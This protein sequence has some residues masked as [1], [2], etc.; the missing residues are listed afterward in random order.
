MSRFACLSAL[1]ALVAAINSALGQAVS[2]AG[3]Q[4]A[5]PSAS[6]DSSKKKTAAKDISGLE[7][8]VVTAERRESTVQKTPIS[9]TAVS[10]ADIL[11]RGL[12]DM[13]SIAQQTPGISFRTAGPGQTE[14]EMRGL[15]STGGFSPTVGFYVDD[16]PLTAPAE[17][18]QGKIVIDPDLYDLNR[19]EVLRGPQGTLYGS[20]SMGG[21]IKLVTNPP[22]LNKF[23]VSAQTKDSDTDGGGFNYGVSAMLNIPLVQD[24]VAL[25]L[26]G[27]D[28]YVAGWID[29]VVLNPF[30]LETNGG[31]SRGNILAAPVQERFSDVNWE[32][33]GGGRISLLIQIG[34]R[35]TITPGAMYQR[36]TQGG[37][38]T[39]D[40]PPGTQYAHFEP[41]DVDEP[42]EDDF[43]IYT[44][45][46]KYHFDAFDLSS[47]S[48]SWN[49]HDQQQTDISETM[50][51][52]FGFPSYDTVGA[53]AQHVVD[54]SSQFSQEIRLASNTDG[55]FQWLGGVF[56]SDFHSNTTSFIIYPGFG[57]L[58]GTT[59]L[60]NNTTPLTITQRALFGEASYKIT[61]QLKG[62]LG[63]RYYRY[64]SEDE[65][66]NSGIASI[67]GGPGTIL[68]FGNASNS[69]F[70]PR[71][72]LAYTVS[73]DVLLYTTAAKGFRPG[74]PNSPVPLKGPVQCL[75]GPGNLQSLGLTSA[76]NQFDPDGVWSYEVGEKARMMGNRVTI[77]ADI[78]Y[79]NWTNVQQAVDPSCGFGFTANAG[80]ARIYGSEIEFAANL[81]PEWT[82]TQNLGLT[83]ATFNTTVLATDTAK[84]AKVL[85][86]PNVTANT[87]IIYTKPVNAT[88][89]FNARATYNY[90]GPMQ[91]ITY[92]RNDLAG[93]SLLNARFGLVRDAFSAFV[94][95][96][97]VTDKFAVLTN[98][99]SNTVN[100]PIFNRLV[101]NQPRTI[102]VDFQF[103]Y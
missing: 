36:I 33:L 78:F 100:V 51:F 103:R 13:Q 68:E 75:T 81:T 79:E 5:E 29:R 39:A 46:I 7:E 65:T 44:L 76:P 59:N 45:G 41:F 92:V 98:W 38:N 69:G 14:Y 58:F 50:Q 8:I 47:A 60:I 62:T 96:D 26:V 4:S 18:V 49:R 57:P 27:T 22:E 1:L 53:G 23:S 82:V 43:S 34:D 15:T 52:L 3:S 35:L 99:N 17:A 21:T 86:V 32:R 70:N 74:G 55:K 48:S 88:Y 25:R 24:V 97:N 80:A 93:Y 64:A 71:V 95:V 61:D 94:Y 63:F 101:V 91:D 37:P 56:F 11:A 77:N 72:N 102:G 89:N 12:G 19:V 67:A 54:Y 10:G 28:K 31:L 16:A 73:D 6:S 85:D 20:G 40:N 90:V 66:T 87:S 2:P 42:S 83:H 84:G 9:M 30:P